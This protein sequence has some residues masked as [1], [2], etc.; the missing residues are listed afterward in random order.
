MSGTSPSRLLVF[1]RGAAALYVIGFGSAYLGFALGWPQAVDTWGSV[2]AAG[3][4][5]WFGVGLL[6]LETGGAG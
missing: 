3:G 6:D 4:L 5:G 2:V 1:S